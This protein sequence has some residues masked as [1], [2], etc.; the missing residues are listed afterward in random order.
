M[1]FNSRTWSS[2]CLS[3]GCH[4]LFPLAYIPYSLHSQREASKCIVLEVYINCNYFPP[5]SSSGFSTYQGIFLVRISSFLISVPFNEISSWDIIKSCFVRG[6]CCKGRTGHA[7]KQNMHFFLSFSSHT[8]FPNVFLI[9][10]ACFGLCTLFR[11]DTP[12]CR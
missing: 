5:F 1:K 9:M 6:S 2:D 10:S 11:K 8:F 4:F 7:F 3:L 12:Y